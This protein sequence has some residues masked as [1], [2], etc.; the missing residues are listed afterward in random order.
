MNLLYVFADGAKGEASCPW[1]NEF[2]FDGTYPY[3]RMLRDARSG[4]VD[5]RAV[6]WYV[7]AFLAGMYTL[8][9]GTSLAR[10]IGHDG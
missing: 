1:R 2:D 8:Y 4:R 10:N 6:H 7:S 3:W 5:S 9:P